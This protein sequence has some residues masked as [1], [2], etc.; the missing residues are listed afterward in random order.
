MSEVRPEDRFR[1]KVLSSDNN[2]APDTF[3]YTYSHGINNEKLAKITATWK[4]V[5]GFLGWTD[6][7]KMIDIVS[8]YQASIDGKY[9]NDFVKIAELQ[10]YVNTLRKSR[11]NTPTGFYS[12][13]QAENE[14]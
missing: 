4:M 5:M 3:E 2:F 8:G 14:K 10:H 13:G 1:Q 12:S 9:H 7:V 11:S 6:E